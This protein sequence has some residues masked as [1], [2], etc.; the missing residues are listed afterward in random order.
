M[1]AISGKSPRYVYWILGL[2]LSGCAQMQQDVLLDLESQ[3]RA[4]QTQAALQSVKK[5]KGMGKNRALYALNK[6]MIL[7]QAGDYSGSIKAFERAKRRIGVLDPISI[8][9]SLS[10]YTVTEQLAAYRATTYER[11]FL[12]WYQIMNYLALNDLDAARVEVMQIDLALSTLTD[13]G[14]FL[15]AA[16]ARYVS[17]FIFEAL[18]EADNALIAYRRAHDNYRRGR[19][20]IPLDLQKRL[21]TLSAALGLVEE[22]RRW[23]KEFDVQREPADARAG[24]LLI[25]FHLDFAPRKLHDSQAVIDPRTGQWYRVSLPYYAPRD[26]GGIRFE[27]R[28][29]ENRVASE[30]LADI[31][32]IAVN[33]LQKQMP[34]LVMRAASRNVARRAATKRAAEEGELLG[35]LVN[36]VGALFDEAD[37]R[38]W[39][40]L[41]NQ[42]QLASHTLIPGRHTLEINVVDPFGDVIDR[43]IIHDLEIQQRQKTFLSF[44]WLT[45]AGHRLH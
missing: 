37:V 23:R 10:A 9:E 30:T 24:E 22:Q 42:I 31:E 19:A 32:M 26:L 38:N 34:K 7:H 3:L 43:H 2:L 11:L 28:V 33:D 17:G 25:F 27:T 40:T 20:A 5:L 36:I 44:H 39:R 12:H 18:G 45:P 29:M 15:A 16:A 6:G 8:T 41:P 21:A 14:H 1:T 35:G 13:S 4:R